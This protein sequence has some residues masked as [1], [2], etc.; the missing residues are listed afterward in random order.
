MRFSCF[1]EDSIFLILCDEE[2]GV[3]DQAD[4]RDKEALQIRSRA[5]AA[6]QD[7]FCA[8]TRL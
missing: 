4:V 6:A 7:G 5:G 2:G 3:N 8:G 1:D